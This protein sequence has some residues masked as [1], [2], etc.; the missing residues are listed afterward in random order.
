MTI[1]VIG[2]GFGRTGTLSIKHA[3]EHLNLGPC[4]HMEDVFHNPVQLPIWQAA[5]NG[6]AMDWQQALAGYRS[7]IDWPTTHFWNDLAEAF[8]EARVLLSVRPV[9]SWWR[10]F[11]QTIKPLLERRKQIPDEHIQAVLEMAYQMIAEQGFNGDMSQTN[12]MAVYQ[13]RIDQ[14]R[15][16]IPAERLLEY[17]VS[18][19]WGPLCD[20]LKLPVPDIDF[21]RYNSG[22]EFWKTFGAGYEI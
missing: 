14:V 3:L 5:L 16:N 22:R 13:Q 6:Q 18:Q 20:F 9:E 21:P 15:Q 12:A 19:G 11:S 1:H 2:A 7:T 17:D 4:H 10:S 8:P